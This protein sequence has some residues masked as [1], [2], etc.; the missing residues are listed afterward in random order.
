[1]GPRLR[2]RKLG[3]LALPTLGHPGG[4]LDSGREA[5]FGENVFDMAFGGPLGD[6]HCR[7]YLRV[8]QPIRYEVG[9]LEFPGQDLE[10]LR[11]SDPVRKPAR[12]ARLSRDNAVAWPTSPFSQAK[13]HWAAAC[14]NTRRAPGRSRRSREGWRWPHAYRPPPSDLRKSSQCTRTDQISVV[15]RRKRLAEQKFRAIG[16]SS[17]LC[18]RRRARSWDSVSKLLP[19]SRSVC[20]NRYRTRRPLRSAVRI[21]LSTSP[22]STSRTAS[23]ASPSPEQISSAASTS[24]SFGIP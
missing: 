7:G 3:D 10:A 21:D 2:E 13:I 17:P 23:D 18:M 4:D 8:T 15:R 22:A 16:R 6:D 12:S 5:Q 9:D 24:R 19:Y 11:D 1:M 20:G 14:S